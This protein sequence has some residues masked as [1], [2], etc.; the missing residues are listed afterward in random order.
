[1]KRD[2]GSING[3]IEGIGGLGTDV[4]TLASLQ[5]QLA[6]KD[7]Q[8]MTERVIPAVVSVALLIPLAFA[9]FTAIL[10]GLAYWINA[11]FNVPIPA[12]LAVMGVAGLVLAGLLAFFAKNRF[13]ASMVAFR[14]SRE[15]LERNL[16]WLG[17]VLKQS[18]R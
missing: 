10:F 12:S 3:M 5:A 14:R 13:G 1:M 9:G 11:A 6:A 7:L 2:D 18:G 4:V 17:T 8:A 16:S 15:E